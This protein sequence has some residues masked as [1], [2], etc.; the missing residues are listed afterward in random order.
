MAF[1]AILP[2]EALL[3][4]TP[5]LGH[6]A[7][8]VVVHPNVTLGRDVR[9]W[10][11]VTLSVSDTPGAS[12][13]LTIGNRVEVGTGAVILTPLRDSLSIC[14]DVKIGANSVVTR[15]IVIPGTYAGAP[16]ILVKEFE[17]HQ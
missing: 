13:R 6:F 14:D 15:T 17:G 7:M 5:S 10:H 4:G 12:A 3:S 9:I 8:N 1:R 16:A 11:G 2:P